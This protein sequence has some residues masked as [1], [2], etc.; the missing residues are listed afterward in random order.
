MATKT[1]SLDEEAYERLKARK[2]EGESF[3]ETVK[4]L[5]GERSWNEV[6]GILSGDEAADLEAAIEEGRTKSR[7]RSDRLTVE[8]GEAVDDKTSE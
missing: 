7:V 4:R 6:T 1:I 3:S 2:K 8:L 5:A